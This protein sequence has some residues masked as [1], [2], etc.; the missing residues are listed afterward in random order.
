MESLVEQ[1]YG[2]FLSLEHA[3]KATGAVGEMMQM[4]K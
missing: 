4:Q 1:Q 3:D 2:G